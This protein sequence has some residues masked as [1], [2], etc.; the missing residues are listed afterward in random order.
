MTV[1]S[2]WLILTGKPFQH[3]KLLPKIMALHY[4]PQQCSTWNWTLRYGFSLLCCVVHFDFLS[5]LSNSIIFWWIWLNSDNVRGQ[6]TLAGTSSWV[7]SNIYFSPL[8]AGFQAPNVITFFFFFCG[9]NV[10]ENLFAFITRQPLNLFLTDLLASGC[11]G[12][13]ET[14]KKKITPVSHV[15]FRMSWRPNP[16]KP[17]LQPFDV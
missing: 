17:R 16:P 15:F 3:M 1:S 13:L 12:G 9:K 6:R 10:S 7:I 14:H 5:L 2:S 11:L 4:P 8:L